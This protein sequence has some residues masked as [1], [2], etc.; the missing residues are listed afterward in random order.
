MPVQAQ[1][2]MM[3]GGNT[4]HIRFSISG[5]LHLQTRS[6]LESDPLNTYSQNTQ[7]VTNLLLHAVMMLLC[8][9]QGFLHQNNR[10][11]PIL[12]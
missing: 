3:V 5:A 7:L 11:S 6:K 10:V 2:K 9:L 4:L 1:N 8:S 12:L